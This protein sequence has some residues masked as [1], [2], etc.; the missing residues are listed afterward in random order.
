[1]YT[2]LRKG[3]R[4]LFYEKA[5]YH[6]SEISFRANFIHI[7]GISLI[8]DTCETEKSP[9]TLVT[10]P[11]EW[12]IKIQSLNDILSTD[13]ISFDILPNDVLSIIDSYI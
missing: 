7:L 6:E 1:M 12:I 10:I 5:P 3:Q 2:H 9:T 8:I 11:I 13:D 4:Y